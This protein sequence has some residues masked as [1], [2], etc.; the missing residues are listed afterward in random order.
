MKEGLDA[1]ADKGADLGSATG[2][3]DGADMAG[4]LAIS[5]GGCVEDEGLKLE[6]C[7]APFEASSLTGLPNLNGLLLDWSP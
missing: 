2:G 5:A 7:L 4:D 3:E 1:G 6:N